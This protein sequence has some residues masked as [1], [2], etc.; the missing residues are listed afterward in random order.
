MKEHA[1]NGSAD[2]SRETDRLSAGRFQTESDRG[3]ATL[4][5]CIAEGANLSRFYGMILG[6][7]NVSFGIRPGITGVVGPNGAGKTTLF[8]LL[9]GQIKPSSGMLNVFGERPW[10]NP[11]VQARIAYCPES[12]SVPSSIGAFPRSQGACAQLPRPGEACVTA[13]EET[14]HCAVQ[15]HAPARET[16]AVPAA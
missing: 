8:R 4:R 12:E 2:V 1:E 16:R 3:A 11:L 10:N 7:N 5:P 15:R 6:L 9:L 13:L 14:A